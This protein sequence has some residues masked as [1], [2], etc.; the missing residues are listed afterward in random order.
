MDELANTVGRSYDRVAGEYA[1]RIFDELRDKPLDRAL[2]ERFA[3]A[4]RAA[5]VVYDLGTGPGHVARYLHERGVDVVGL[6]ISAEMVAEARRRCPGIVFRVGDLRAPEAPAG[7]LAGITAFYSI[8]HVPRTDVTA[9]LARWREALRPGGIV[10]LGFHVGAETLHLDEWW[11]QPV[12][13][14]FAFFGVDEMRGYL[15]AAGLE[16][17][18]V[19]ERPPYPDVEHPSQRAYIFARRPE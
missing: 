18:E 15:S 12:T 5:G 11:E 10:L 8:I 2:L 13:L 4:T 1:A 9:A 6:D 3:D 7:S 14:D 16:V 19:V 17:D